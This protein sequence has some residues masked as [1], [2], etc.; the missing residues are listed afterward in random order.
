MWIGYLFE[1]CL[2]S[3]IPELCTGAATASETDPCGKRWVEHGHNTCLTNV[4]QVTDTGLNLSIFKA[5]MGAQR[6]KSSLRLGGPQ[7]ACRGGEIKADI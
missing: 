5:V 6:K 4:H 1:N 7:N 2:L 3:A